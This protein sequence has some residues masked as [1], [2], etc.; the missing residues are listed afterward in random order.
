M[1]VSKQTLKSAAVGALSGAFVFAALTV[2]FAQRALTVSDVRSNGKAYVGSVTTVSGLAYYVRQE[3]RKRNNQQT[4]YVKLSLYETD[5]KGNKGSHY[6]YVALP[7]SSFA[8]MP[9]EGQSLNVTGP[10]KW[11]YE[12]AVIEE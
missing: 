3:T 6:V 10:L 5:S 9:S 12:V 2:A 7:A 11:P 4:P 1:T 8:F